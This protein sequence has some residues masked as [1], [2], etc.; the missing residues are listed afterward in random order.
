MPPGYV[1]PSE[2]Y[3]FARP[4]PVRDGYPEI[5]CPVGIVAERHLVSHR[6]LGQRLVIVLL[7][8]MSQ[9]DLADPVV[10]HA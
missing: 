2:D 9:I 1:C 10:K 7:A 6:L 5:I 3:R 8:Q 4:V